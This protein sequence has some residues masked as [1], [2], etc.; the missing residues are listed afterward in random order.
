VL[1]WLIY[2]NRAR[3]CTSLSGLGGVGSVHPP[4]SRRSAGREYCQRDYAAEML[5]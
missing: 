1:I 5:S 4:Q 3:H 2:R